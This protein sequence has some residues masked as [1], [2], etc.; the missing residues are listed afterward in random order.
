MSS[1]FR[2]AL[3]GAISLASQAGWAVDCGKYDGKFCNGKAFQYEGGFKPNAGEYGGFGGAANCTASKTPVVFLHGNADN[4]TSWDSPTFQVPGYPKP[5]R[6]V[7]EEFKAAGYQDCELF[8]LS[9]LNEVERASEQ[10]NYHEPARYEKIDKFIQA[11]KQ[12]TGKD[13]VDIIGHSLGV[14]LGMATLTHY[15]NWPQVRRFVNI[16][17]GLHGLDSCILA[18]F[19]NPFVATCGSQ[20]I[21]VPDTFGFYPDSASPGINAWTGTKDKKSL[22]KSPTHHPEVRFYTIYAGQNDQYM[23]SS[24]SNRA[25]CGNSPLLEKAANVKAQINIGTGSKTPRGQWDWLSGSPTDAKGGDIDGVGHVHARNNSGSIMV[26]ML[27]SECSS[28][29]AKNYKYGPVVYAK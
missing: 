21:F 25:T 24:D 19:A 12:Y 27:G 13:R 8:G 20:N 29:C 17:G 7:Y 6:S 16:A 5:P 4:A 15:K 22:S 26:H 2:I 9:Y 11:V 10:L 18:G 23:C 28:Q 1:F 3:I 14:S